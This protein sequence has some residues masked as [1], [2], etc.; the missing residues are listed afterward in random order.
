MST[1]GRLRWAIFSTSVVSAIDNPDAY[2]WRALGTRLRQMGHEAIFFE[3]RGNDAVRALLH[4]SGSAAL[5]EFRVR[6]A[7]IEYRTFEPRTGADLVEWMTRTLATVDVAVIQASAAAELV[8]WL[9]KLTRPHLRTFYVDTGWNEMEPAGD[10]T[11]ES[12]TGFTA[13]VAGS[14]ERAALYSACAP[15]CH[16]L[17]FGSLPRVDNVEIPLPAIT[18][19]LVTACQWLIDVVCADHAKA[20]AE[21]RARVSPNGHLT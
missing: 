4:R 20:T 19:E 18:L 7:D 21:R 5:T 8:K 6:H 12:L 17:S 16:V 2:L 1:E 9:A 3:P 10:Q 13:I 14:A 11:G 15:A